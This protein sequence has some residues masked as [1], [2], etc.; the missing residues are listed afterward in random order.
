M[1]FTFVHRKMQEYEFERKI[2]TSSKLL[3]PV[4]ATA[5]AQLIARHLFMPQ[6]PSWQALSLWYPRKCKTVD[7]FTD[8]REPR[9]EDIRRL[10]TIPYLARETALRRMQKTGCT[11]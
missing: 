2:K 1:G 6:R 9:L 11:H 5:I 4:R 3:E 10:R 8:Q 7:T